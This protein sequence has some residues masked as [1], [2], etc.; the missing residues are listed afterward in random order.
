M[1]TTT[2]SASP[3]ATAADYA[4]P[5]TLIYDGPGDDEWAGIDTE[6]RF[7]EDR[8]AADAPATALV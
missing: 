5:S 4:G 6:R 7:V 1:P 8:L 2:A 3:R